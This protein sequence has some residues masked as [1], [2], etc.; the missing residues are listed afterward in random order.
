MNLLLAVGVL[1]QLVQ[2]YRTPVAIGNIPATTT[3]TITTGQIAED[4]I[5]SSSQQVPV[6]PPRDLRVSSLG[7]TPP[8]VAQ[9]VQQQENN[10]APGWR[11]DDYYND[12]SLM[13]REEEPT[14]Y[15]VVHAAAKRR[16][17]L[18]GWI[19]DHE[20]Q[21]QEFQGSDNFM[22]DSRHPEEHTPEPPEPPFQASKYNYSL[23]AKS[24]VYTLLTQPRP[25][26]DS[27]LVVIV[28]SSRSNFD[29]R[30]A[31]RESWAHGHQNVYFVIGGPDPDKDEENS[32]SITSPNSTS[33]FSRL[34]QE[35]NQYRDLLDTIHPES[36]RGLPYKL[37]YAIRW[38]G[39]H[40][41]M[42]HVDW[43]L[44]V[45]DDIVARLH[46]LQYYVL[47]KLNP[48]IPMVIGRVD[49]HLTAP[50]RTGKWAE[51]PVMTLTTYP[52]WAYGSTGYVMS[53]PVT[54]YIA[55]QPS[56]YYYQGEDVS[57][58]LW[59]YESPLDMT[60]MN[61]PYFALDRNTTHEES[62]VDHTHSVII[63][64][65]LSVVALKATF[66]LWPDPKPQLNTKHVN[67]KGL[68]FSVKLS[69]EEEAAVEDEN[70]MG[71][72]TWYVQPNSRWKGMN[73]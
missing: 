19:L 14:T 27:N 57:L 39:Q 11:K 44:K 3:T 35:Q 37:H 51:D 56:L 46:A 43:I 18:N 47:R 16:Y 9:S 22:Q 60:W 15:P 40:P 6:L 73:D 4:N 28:L 30:Q 34:L 64:H 26:N 13:S 24:T 68:I 71:D 42:K 63:G 65:N 23:P 36:Y 17:D 70:L 58:G 32:R 12:E 25:T 29:R 55:S 62:I 48:M 7:T 59:L 49:P 21:Q 53:R 54:D 10:I 38:I 67:E 31:I 41:G 50:H 45:D 2:I 69:S 52:P 33:S 8:L 1:L 72:D 20:Q 61:V 5:K 66:E